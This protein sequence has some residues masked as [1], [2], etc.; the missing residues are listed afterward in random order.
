[1]EIALYTFGEKGEFRQEKEKH[2]Q[3]ILIREPA[4]LTRCPIIIFVRE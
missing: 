1:M 3:D 4:A 2:E